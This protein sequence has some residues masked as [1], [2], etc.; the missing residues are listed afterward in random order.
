M[1]RVLKSADWFHSD[2][3]PIAVERREPQGEFERHTHEFAELVIVTG[4]RALHVTGKEAWKLARGDVFVIT[5]RRTHEYRDLEDLRLVNVLFQPRKLHLDLYDLRTLP[6]YHALFTLEPTWRQR[7]QFQSRL[8]ITPRDLAVVGGLIDQLDGEL[9]E[10]AAGFGF[11]ATA[12]FM[13]LVGYLSRCYGRARNRDS[14]SLLRIAETITHLETHSTEPIRLDDLARQAGM[15]KRSFIR[16]F[17]EA[18]GSP[19]IAYLIQLRVDRAATLFRQGAD[20]V[21]EV[22]F[23]VG[24]DDSNYFSRQFRRAL[25]MSPRAYRKTHLGR[26]R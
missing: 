14:R 26:L 19:P 8:R 10:R 15:S 20:N 24:F 16:A 4:G 9:R 7:H 5:G 21:T 11:L 6:G 1:P 13:Q 23:Q 25:G 12:L 18:T 22:A 3:F 2:G 17:K